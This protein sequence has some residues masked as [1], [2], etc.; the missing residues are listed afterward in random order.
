MENVMTTEEYANGIN[1][2]EQIFDTD[3][4]DELKELKELVEDL[5]RYEEI[6]HP[7]EY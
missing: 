4:E 7:L 3:D 6:Y 1:R 2:M 5:D